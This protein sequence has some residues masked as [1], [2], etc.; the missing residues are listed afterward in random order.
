LIL[1][2]KTADVYDGLQLNSEDD[3]RRIEDSVRYLTQLAFETK[4]LPK[5]TNEKK[6]AQAIKAG[7]SGNGQ[8]SFAGRVK[9]SSLNRKMRKLQSSRKDLF[10]N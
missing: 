7:T 10:F 1:R 9:R 2:S 5:R 4:S 8:K 6:S 3:W